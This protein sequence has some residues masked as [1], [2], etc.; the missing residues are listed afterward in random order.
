MRASQAMSASQAMKM[1]GGGAGAPGLESL[2]TK[3]GFTQAFGSKIA[4]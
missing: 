3:E 2:L 4:G 1:M